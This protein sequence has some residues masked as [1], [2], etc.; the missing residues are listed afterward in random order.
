[1]ADSNLAGVKVL[2][3]DDE[4]DARALVERLLEE[5]DATVTTAAS[6]SEALELVARDKPDVLLSDIGM[7]KEDGYT[8]IRRIRKLDGA[9]EFLQSR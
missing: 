2:V 3:V 6:A 8:L 7:P 5:C 9:R 1:M 4:P